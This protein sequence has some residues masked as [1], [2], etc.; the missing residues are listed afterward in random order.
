MFDA[1]Y[2]DA[3]GW[4]ESDTS[5][6]AAIAIKEASGP[7]ARAVHSV[8]RSAPQG[9]TSYE[10]ADLLQMQHGTVQPRTSELKLKGLIRDSGM[11]RLN[12]NRRRAIVWVAIEGAA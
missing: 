12:L 4:K 2:P 9:L 11:R 10:I 8:I 1:V 3:P 6:E 5:R 7:I